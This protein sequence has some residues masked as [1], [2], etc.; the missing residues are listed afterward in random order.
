MCSVHIVELNVTV[1]NIKM[2]NVSQ[3]CFD[4]EFTS[5]ERKKKYSCLGVSVQYFLSDFNQFFEFIDRFS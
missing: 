1:N 2:S 3:Q 5:P 4:G